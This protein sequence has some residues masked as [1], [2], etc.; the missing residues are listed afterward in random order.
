MSDFLAKKGV[1]LTGNL[2]LKVSLRSEITDNEVPFVAS[3]NEV[4]LPV[5]RAEIISSGSA[6]A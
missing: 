4:P 6:G 5:S 3:A 2:T 1:G